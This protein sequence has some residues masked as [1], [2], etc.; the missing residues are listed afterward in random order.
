M[1][2]PGLGKS[3]VQAAR[4]FEGNPSILGAVDE[5]RWRMISA[6]MVDGRNV[7]KKFGRQMFVIHGGEE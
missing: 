5:Q 6:H 2:G 3:L 4:L 7:V 1:S